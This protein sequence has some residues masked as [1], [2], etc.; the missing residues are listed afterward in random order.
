MEDNKISIK[1]IIAI[2]GAFMGF[3]IGSSFASGQECMQYFTGFGVLKSIGA[4]AIALVLYVWFVCTIV[5]DGR[6]LKL[7]NPGNM[8]S[9]YLG[10]YLGKVMEWFTPIMLFF[11]YSLM[12]SG[13]GSTFE[14]YYGVNGNI[15]RAIMIIASLGTVLLGL[16]K[17]VQIV[18]YI[19]PVLLVV[20]IVIGVLSIMNNP[21]GIAE[22]DQNLAQVK[23]HTN[24]NNWMLSGFMYGA[25]TVTG[26]VPYLAG[27]GSTTATNK[28]NAF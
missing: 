17:L 21:Q 13:A 2:G 12:I 6:Y 19:A 18:G 25:Y 14:E 27:I 28:K 7:K 8:F 11:V 23:V 24:F 1:Q 4:G 3:V 22:A 10:K 16:K 20:T 15:G 9:F 26:V 5:E